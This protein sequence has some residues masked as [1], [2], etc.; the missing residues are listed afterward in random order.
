MAIRSTERRRPLR[1]TR[2]EESAM[3]A[4][5]RPVSEQH[6]T[7]K[8]CGALASLYGVVDFHKNCARRPLALSG[9]PIYYHRCTACGFIFTTAF[10][11]FTKADFHEHIYNADYILVDPDYRDVRPRGNESVL[12]ALLSRG[13]PDRMLDY[14]GGEGL[15]AQLLRASGFPQVDTYDPFVPRYDTRPSDRYDCVV[16]FE[17]AEHT[18]DPAHT[19]ADINEF[20]TD[21]GIIIFSTLLQPKNIDEQGLSW[22]YVGPRNGHVSLYT[23]PSLVKLARPL[24]LALRSFNYNLHVLYRQIPPFAK[25]FIVT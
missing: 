20:L 22:W 17:V 23:G 3:N 21:T 18:T 24:G 16:S 10:D 14:G 11:H 1:L 5:L 19:F 7:C 4:E 9:V 25:H 8:C 2:T 15:L 12:R 13:K 6:A